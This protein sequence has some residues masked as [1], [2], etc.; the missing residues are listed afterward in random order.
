[1][2]IYQIP[3]E[4]KIYFNRFRDLFS[5]KQFNYFQI[6]IFS[7]IILEPHQKNVTQIS[8]AWVEPVC[9]SSLE[10]FLSEYKWEFQKVIRRS[11]RQIIRVLS[12]GRKGARKLQLV[13]D[14]TTL[15]K[16]GKRIFGAAWYKKNK[17]N[18]LYL[19]IQVVVIGILDNNWLI[20]I[21]FH[22]YVKEA[23]CE[24]I[25]LKFETKL[26]QAV[27]MLNNLS[28]PREY[29]VEVM[30]DSWYLNDL[31]TGAIEKKDWKW[32]SRCASNRSILWEGETGRQNFK[33]YVPTIEWKPLKYDTNRKNPAVVGHQRIGHLKKIGRI[34]VVFSSLTEDGSSRWAAFCTNHI[35]LPMVTVISRFEKRWKIEVFFKEARKN[36]GLACWQYRDTV[37]VVNH[38]CLTL[39][40]A[41]TCAYMRI[42][43]L[44]EGRGN[45]NESWGEFVR[46]LQKE[47]QRSVLRYFL[48]FFEKNNN[49]DFN[50][51]C[52]E[53]GF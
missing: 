23:E 5:L 42:K 48:E 47:N 41:M 39:V 25:R 35:R 31:V 22:I 13:I 4:F 37:S 26:Q 34:K 30:F 2:K 6:Y 19:G 16:F 10:R 45:L 52:D 38:L 9:R 50:G 28:L 53:L 15:L 27:K 43:E 21:D 18:P 49:L 20:P 8:R 36:F 3:K 17:N 11:R 44:E 24:Y 32:I 33:A 40:A 46:K 12:Q 1:M 29:S 51:L 14:D 7:L